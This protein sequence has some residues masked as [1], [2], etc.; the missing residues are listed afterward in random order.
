M[1]AVNAFAASMYQKECSSATPRSNGFC[2][3]APHDVAKVTWPI[4]S[5]AVCARGVAT[6]AATTSAVIAAMVARAVRRFIR[7]I[8]RGAG[9]I[10]RSSVSQRVRA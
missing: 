8:A 1:T 2:T 7:D 3:A 4:R 9:F 10:S 5:L 6:Q